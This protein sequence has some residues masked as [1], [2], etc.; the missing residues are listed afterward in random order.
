MLDSYLAAQ[1]AHY[2]LDTKR[3]KYF[4]SLF[5]QNISVRNAQL[6]EAMTL[7]IVVVLVVGA[8]IAF[9]AYQLV[10]SRIP[11]AHATDVE[12]SALRIRLTSSVI[13]LVVLFISLVFLYIYVKEVF[14]A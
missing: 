3:S 2:D 13:G 11:G 10:Q 9:S 8:G 14:Q 6:W 5:D 7:L 12:L 4:E 1:K